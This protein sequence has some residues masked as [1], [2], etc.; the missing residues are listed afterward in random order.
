V[1][2]LLERTLWLAHLSTFGLLCG[3]LL[4]VNLIAVGLY[5]AMVISLTVSAW[6]TRA[7]E[8]TRIGSRP[9]TNTLSP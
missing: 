1:A 9:P 7:G 5:F 4:G 6:M 3:A 2:P 8:N